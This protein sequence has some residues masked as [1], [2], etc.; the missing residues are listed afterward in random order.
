MIRL[1]VT[2]GRLARTDLPDAFETNVR[3]IGQFKR[4]FR[5]AGE[6]R[7]IPRGYPQRLELLELAHLRQGLTVIAS[8]EE[9]HA[10]LQVLGQS[11]LSTR[12]LQRLGIQSLKPLRVREQHIALGRRAR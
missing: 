11:L 12:E 4:D 1:A 8:F 10:A 2:L 5:H 6:P 7:E 9:R 3:H